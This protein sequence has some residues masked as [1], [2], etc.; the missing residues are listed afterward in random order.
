MTQ[1]L[2]SYWKPETADVNLQGGYSLN[3]SASNQYWR[4]HVGDTVWIVTVRDGDLYLLGRILVAE[5]TDQQGAIRA[6]QTTDLWRA[7]FHIL[8]EPETDE[9][10]RE[11]PIAQLAPRLRFRSRAGND[12]LAVVDGKVNPQQ[13]QTMRVLTSDAA[14]LLEI[15]LEGGH[16]SDSSK[17]KPR[18]RAPRRTQTPGKSASAQDGDPA[19]LDSL[20][21]LRTAGRG[22]IDLVKPEYRNADRSEVDLNGL[23]YVLSECL[24]HLFPGV[25][26][27]YRISWDNGGTHYFL[28]YSD[29]RILDAIAPDGRE[30]CAPH[31]YQRA[32]RVAFFTKKP[33][34]RASKLLA[35]A[36]FGDPTKGT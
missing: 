4:V 1:H 15:A 29:G 2:L 12:R 10:I 27:P 21:R 24:Y 9:V 16:H 11:I 5:V 23:C 33:S 35:R 3:H 8:A 20:R 30:C 26:T 14:T 6:F 31:D 25:L 19:I 32:R 22:S 13:L 17:A 36:G 28:R 7:D 34:R 18:R